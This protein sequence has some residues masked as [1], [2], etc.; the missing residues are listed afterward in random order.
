VRSLRTVAALRPRRLFDGHRGLVDDP[1]PLLEAKAGWTEDVIARVEALAAR[2]WPD[3]RIRDAV[4]G[5]E[6]VTGLASR[7]EY[8]KLNLVRVIRA[9]R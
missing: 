3:A 5:R 4:L 8:A 9:G 6:P 1:V 7:G 2:G